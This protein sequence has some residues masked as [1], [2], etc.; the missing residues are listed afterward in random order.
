MVLYLVSREATERF[1]RESIKEAERNKGLYP[2]DRNFKKLLKQD[3]LLS[4]YI[5]TYEESIRNLGFTKNDTDCFAVGALTTRDLFKIQA[6]IIGF[7]FL[8]LSFEAI[9]N[10]LKLIE[11][12]KAIYGQGQYPYPL[13]LER[14][15]RENPVL[16]VYIR[17]NMN[18]LG[19]QGFPNGAVHTY[20]LYE[21]QALLN[22]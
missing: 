15:I 22:Q 18:Y 13:E 21:Q 10:F 20:L 19:S 3:P 9:T 1:S 6:E 14:I 12:N 4:S 5:I 8:V 2:L 17:E 16:G 11:M 7:N